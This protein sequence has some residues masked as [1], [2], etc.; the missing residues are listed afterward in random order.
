MEQNVSLNYFNSLY[1][2]RG[3]QYKIEGKIEGK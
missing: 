3:K 2:F 1:S